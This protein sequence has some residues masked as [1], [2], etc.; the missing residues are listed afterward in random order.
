MGLRKK[1]SLVD[2]AIDQ[3]GEYVDALRP[4]VES[5]Y[6]QAK[7]FVQDTAI[8]ALHD[9]KDKAGPAL[10]DAR[11]KAVPVLA[12]ARD[13]AVPLVSEARDKA[14]PLIADARAKAV[15][16]VAGGAA[17]AGERATAVK[18][19]AEEKVAELKGEKPKKRS[20]IKTL[21]VLGVVAGG[22]A[23][24]AKKLQSPKSDN[25]QSSYT[26]KPAPAAA[27]PSV[28]ASP[29][30]TDTGGA[31]PDEALADAVEAP[32]PVSTPD[33]PVEVVDVDPETEKK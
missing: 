31:G 16:L 1:K 11:E 24:V 29:A 9:A 30:V 13:R 18:V 10:A 22:V 17:V 3:A 12:E 6:G 32:H 25:W 20:K 28:P 4:H 5:A 15:P 8:P 23:V 33:E 26:P 27:K 21:L 7:D 14:A 19:L 2:Q